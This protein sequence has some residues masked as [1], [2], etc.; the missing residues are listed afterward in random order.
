MTVQTTNL[1]PLSTPPGA[2]RDARHVAGGQAEYR[3]RKVATRRRD[4]HANRLA[5]RAGVTDY[6]AFRLNGHDIS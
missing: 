5:L 6:R 1:A 3:A 2:K 4:R